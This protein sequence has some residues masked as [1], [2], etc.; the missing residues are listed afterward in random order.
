MTNGGTENGKLIVT[1]DNFAAWG[2]KNRKTICNALRELETA[3]FVRV[4]YAGRVSYGAARNP[5]QYRLTWIGTWDGN[6][7]TN[8]WKAFEKAKSPGANLSLV[9]GTDM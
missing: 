1:Y 7:P 3:G 2:V 9:P 5:S 8:E 4:T 6:P